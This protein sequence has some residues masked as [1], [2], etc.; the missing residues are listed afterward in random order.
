[1]GALLSGL[2]G[3]HVTGKTPAD[4]AEFVNSTDNTVMPPY[5][6]QYMQLKQASYDSTKSDL[7]PDMPTLAPTPQPPPPTESPPNT[8]HL[9]SSLDVPSLLSRLER[10]EQTVTRLAANAEQ[11]SFPKAMIEP[12]GQPPPYLMNVTLATAEQ[13]QTTVVDRLERLENR[14]QKVT[15]N[16][17]Q[18][19]DLLARS[20]AAITTHLELVS[21]GPKR[22][23]IINGKD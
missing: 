7:L 16:F 20:M 1:M 17:D 4:I 10:L 5:L 14:L 6:M 18:K 19:L 22:Q 15:Q 3:L 11:T 13:S 8:V 12:S 21:T 9:E 2:Q 23:G